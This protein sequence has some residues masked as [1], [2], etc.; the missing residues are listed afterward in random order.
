MKNISEICKIIIEKN[1]KNR[2]TV[3]IKKNE[4]LTTLINSELVSVAKFLHELLYMQLLLYFVLREY[5][6]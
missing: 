3:L 6:E 1:A 4:T 2:I 5:I